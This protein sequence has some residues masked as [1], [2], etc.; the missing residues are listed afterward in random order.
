VIKIREDELVSKINSLYSE[1]KQLSNKQVSSN[2]NEIDLQIR[3]INNQI[4]VLT[5]ELNNSK[6]ESS[7][8]IRFNGNNL[9]LG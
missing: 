9:E 8:S 4:D 6:I 2:K 3:T 1:R 7:S 5:S